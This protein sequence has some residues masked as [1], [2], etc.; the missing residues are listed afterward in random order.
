MS[1]G[2]QVLLAEDEVTIAETLTDALTDAGHT[3]LKAA[4]TDAALELLDDRNPELVLT[5]V[6]MPGEGG[7]AILR[8]SLERDPDRPVI[9]FTGFATV[10]QAVEAMG[11]GAAWYVQKPFSNEAMVQLV[12]RFGAH[13]RAAAE[14]RELKRELAHFKSIEGM[15]GSLSLIHI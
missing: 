1:S 8:R 4:T 2:F 14:N 15:V 12:G 10:D 3:V 11:E 13:R 6:R 5:D 9:I 7:M